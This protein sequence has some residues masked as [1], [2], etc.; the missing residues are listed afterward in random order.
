MG[1]YNMP[2]NPALIESESIAVLG[3]TKRRRLSLASNNESAALTLLSL[4]GI[5]Q[6]AD[7]DS[8]SATKNDGRFD[9]TGHPKSPMAFRRERSHSSICS[10]VTNDE[11]EDERSHD[12]SARATK[13]IPRYSV[14]S[15][16][17]H[18]L[19]KMALARPS[20]LLMAAKPPNST[21]TQGS[22]PP[23]TKKQPEFAFIR[24]P[25]GRPL[26]PPPRLPR[27]IVSAPP[28]KTL[29]RKNSS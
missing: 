22:A 8:S 20:F 13:N 1:K 15:Q 7:G 18:P 5:H 11:G 4:K 14:P 25:E 17:R 23:T 26:P 3:F 9:G 19:M 10:S 24:L 21:V 6:K 28:R 12:S 16:E 2:E 27:H 29:K